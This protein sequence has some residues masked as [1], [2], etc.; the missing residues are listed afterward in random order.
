MGFEALLTAAVGEARARKAL[1][2][3]LQV[4]LDGRL[5]SVDGSVA[6]LHRVGGRFVV[7]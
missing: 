7:R 5:L 2:D 4:R 3:D 1:A 6:A